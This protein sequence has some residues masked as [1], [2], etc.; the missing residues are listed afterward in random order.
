MVDGLGTL[1]L[2]ELR[3]FHWF[4]VA[5]N[6]FSKPETYRVPWEMVCNMLMLVFKV[7][8]LQA[9][10]LCFVWYC[11]TLNSRRPIL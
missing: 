3:A 10:T 1:K 9:K 5:E 4:N 2:N 6:V 11:S 8:K 7:F